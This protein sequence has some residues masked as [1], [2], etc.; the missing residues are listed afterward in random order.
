MS[1]ISHVYKILIKLIS[2]K[3]FKN[4][5]IYPN[6]FLHIICKSEQRKLCLSPKNN[7]IS[8]LRQVIRNYTDEARS[9]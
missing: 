2:S 7:D 3:L 6:L 4:S 8:L 9:E 1:K 5:K